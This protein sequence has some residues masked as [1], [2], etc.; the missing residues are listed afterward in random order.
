MILTAEL[1]CILLATLPLVVGYLQFNLPLAAMG[2]FAIGLLWLFSP[3][4]FRVWIAPIGFFIYVCA[5]GIGAWLGLSPIWMAISVL[6]SISAW[7]LAGFSRRLARASPGDDL[8]QMEKRHLVQL[9]CLTGISLVLVLMGLLIHVHIPFWGLFL[10]TL[11]A[12]LGLMQL[13]NR[14]PGRN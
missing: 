13:V 5:S 3:R 4:K 8:R 10:L 7:D 9:A 2:A 6:G 14:I 12:V 11:A 1:I